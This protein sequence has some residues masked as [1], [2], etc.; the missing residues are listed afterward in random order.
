MQLADLEKVIRATINRDAISV[1]Q[2]KSAGI[3]GL[4]DPGTLVH[5]IGGV[6]FMSNTEQIRVL[7]GALAG[8]ACF[9]PIGSVSRNPTTITSSK[10][11]GSLD[12][13]RTKASWSYNGAAIS[14]NWDS[15][16]IAQRNSN[17]PPQ[18]DPA[19]STLQQ[20]NAQLATQ[21]KTLHETMTMA[22][23]G[24]EILNR[25]ALANETV[26]N[27][28]ADIARLQNKSNPLMKRPFVRRT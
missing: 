22:E 21:N 15:P 9:I 8:R 14:S 17:V 18:P 26:T 12:A 7:S 16:V 24:V 19:V 10:T 5:I 11:T 27:R 25:L 4:L 23:L 3:A 28:D 6:S 20:Y 2:M 1:S 13:N